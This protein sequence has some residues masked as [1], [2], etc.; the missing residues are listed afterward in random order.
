MSINTLALLA[1]LGTFLTFSLNYLFGMCMLERPLVIGAVV[2][3]LLG[4]VKTGVLVGAT[5]EV[6]FMGVVNIG[7]VTATD[8]AASTAIATAFA[9]YSGLSIDETVA[10]AIPIGLVSNAAFGLIAQLSNLGAPFLDRICEKGD[11]KGLY[12][13][14]FVMFLF[15]FAIKPLVVYI[16]VLAGAEPIS[17]LLA[18]IPAPLSAGIG[19]ASGLLGAVGMAMLLRMLWSNDIAVYFFL[20]F[21]MVKYLNI[22]TMA[23]AVIGVVIAVVSAIRDLQVLNLEKKIESKTFEKSELSE[24]EDF[25]A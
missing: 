25:L 3:I 2:G 22:P 1:A 8:A 17:G 11:Q 19:A 9:I 15:V 13:Y 20:G 4:D 14:E 5:L 24:E 16:G 7:G 23:I 12:I 10:V 21:V 6:A 18:K